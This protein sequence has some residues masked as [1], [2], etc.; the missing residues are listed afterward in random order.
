MWKPSFILSFIND[1]SKSIIL[2]QFGEASFL[3]LGFL[4][5]FKNVS[6]FIRT[7]MFFYPCR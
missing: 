2:K 5:M 6:V 7:Q 3:Q 1:L 4:K